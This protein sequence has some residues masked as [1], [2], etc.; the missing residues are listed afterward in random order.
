MRTNIKKNV[1]EEIGYISDTIPSNVYEDLLIASDVDNNTTKRKYSDRLAGQI[2][3]QYYIKDNLP[4]SFKQY[5]KLL[6]GEYFNLFPLERMGREMDME[7]FDMWLNVQKKHEYNPMHNHYG[8]LSFVIWIKIPYKLKDEFDMSNSKSS[9]HPWN[10]LFTFITMNRGMSPLFVD[11]EYEGKIILFK[12]S[13]LH[14]VF[15]FYSSE[16]S[17]VSLAGNI[18]INWLT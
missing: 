3:E 6:S 1:L 9:R 7:I 12:S 2:E 17:R 16:E 5:I 15:P 11:S 4:S 10:S 14:Q 13:L 8:D 18:K